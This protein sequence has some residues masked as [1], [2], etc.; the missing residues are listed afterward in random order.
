MFSP[1]KSIDLGIIIGENSH[2]FLSLDEYAEHFLLPFSPRFR[3]IDFVVSSLSSM[4]IKNIVIFTKRD[5]EII[6]NY[7]N[8]GWPLIH[9]TVFDYSDIREK[10][11]AFL[12]EFSLEHP[13]E[14]IFIIKGNYPVWLDM[15]SLKEELEKQ[16]NLAIKTRYNNKTVYAALLVEKD[17]F[18]KKYEDFL[19]DEANLE[20]DLIEK[21]TLE[22]QIPSFDAQGYIMPFR[23]LKE[24]YEIHINMLE[25]YLVFDRFNAYVP[26]RGN[27]A[28]NIS[29]TLGRSSHIINSIVGEN[30]EIN[31]KIENSIIFSNVK[32]DKN[33]SIK[34]SIIFPG[35]HIGSHAQIS[36][37]ILDEYSGDNTIP[38]IEPHA[39]IG[40]PKAAKP[41][42][43]FQDILNFGVTLIGKDLRIPSGFRV[44][45]NCYIDSFVIP[46]T[47]REKK[48]LKDGETILR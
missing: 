42:G 31:G 37:C 32:V 4:D 25:D 38:N 27:I 8:K 26:I 6:L 22:N 2:H 47:I 46:S 9:F 29:S 45:G 21:L 40:N 28:P 3:N 24:Y 19:L 33:A 48:T 18:I 30:V 23:S 35:N 34:N 44:G 1:K 17:S 43:E 12:S 11:V 14:L 41:N 36:H 7:L 39:Q 5:K 10:F 16:K 20:I 13:L 15:R